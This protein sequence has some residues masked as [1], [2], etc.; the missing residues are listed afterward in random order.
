MSEREELLRLENLEV[1]FAI[2]GSLTDR[3]LGRSRGKVRAVDGIDLAI[4]RG[5]I[6]ALVGESGSG[7]TTVGRAITKLVQP[8]GGR[9]LFD[10]ADMAVLQGN[11]ALRP[12]RR[13]VQMIFQG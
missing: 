2:Q 8:T 7:K 13:R 10:G 9:L 5:E 1:H 3:L 11:A 4:G 12:Y 6:V